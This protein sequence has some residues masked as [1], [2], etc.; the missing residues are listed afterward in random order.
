M[1]KVID[2][3]QWIANYTPPVIEFVAVYDPYTGAVTSVGPSHA[4]ESAEYKIV[5]DSTIAE[6]IINA[7]IQ[8][9]HCFVD[10]N[11]KEL[12]IAEVRNMFKID[13][14]LHRVISV[15]YSEIKNVDVYI[16]YKVKN[17]TLTIELAKEL[18]GTKKSSGKINKRNIIWDGTT[19]MDFMITDYN[20]PNVLFEMFSVTINE[21]VGQ[22]K[23]IKDIDYDKF[24]V[25]TRRLFKNYVIEYK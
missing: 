6:E 25:Y 14:M 13:D 19:K 21:L 7:E 15:E 2:F 24:S 5:I 22:S 23:I 9:H 1:E 18:G 10:I 4:F 11:S 12:E 16:T 17:K 8:I 20:D 3:D